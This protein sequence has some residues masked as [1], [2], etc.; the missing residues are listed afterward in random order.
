VVSVGLV[1]SVLAIGVGSGLAGAET[2]KVA[3][4][5]QTLALVSKRTGAV[6]RAFPSFA[7]APGFPSGKRFD[8]AVPDGGSGWFGIEYTALVSGAAS[9]PKLAHMRSD[10]SIDRARPIQLASFGEHALSLSAGRLFVGS[11]LGVQAYNSATGARL[12]T[13]PKITPMTSLVSARSSLIVALAATPSRVYIG[14]QFARV[15]GEP[16]ALVAALDARTGRVLPWRSLLFGSG[17]SAYLYTLGVSGPRLYVGGTFGLGIA[18]VSVRTGAL[19]SWSPHFQS[20]D[21]ATAVAFSGST[22]LVGGTFSQGGA[23]DAVTG[24]P[25]EWAA[26]M[27]NATRV[28]VSGSTAYIGGNLRSSL[29]DTGDNL[30]AIDLRTGAQTR[31]APHLGR[32]V[33]VG[34]L[35]ASAGNVLVGGDFCNSIG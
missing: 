13:S 26:T 27:D 16:R 28:T 10:G 8:D 34:T 1:V 15:S 11:A 25:R 20:W 29:D 7:Y 9:K 18:A 2:S 24:K 32:Y 21:G 3:P 4:R 30:A 5:C 31:W 23:F 22:V 33:S 35:A 19:S 6:V 12:W 14:G 17:T